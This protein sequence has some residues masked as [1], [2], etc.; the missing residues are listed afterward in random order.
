MADEGRGTFLRVLEAWREAFG[1]PSFLRAKTLARGWLL[2]TGAHRVTAAL[3]AAGVSGHLHH[4]AFHR[5]FSRAKWCPDELGRLLFLRLETLLARAGSLDVVLDDTLAEKPRGP[6]I[7][8][9]GSH[10]DAVRSSR[11]HHVLSFGHVWV[12]LAIRVQLPFASRPWALPLLFRLY[13]NERECEARGDAH[14]KKTELA[15]DM[16]DVFATWTDR[17]VRVLADQAYC[18]NTVQRDLDERFVL[19]G[20]MR[21]DAVLTALPPPNDKPK[22]G[23]PRKRG[24]LLPKPEAHA[25]NPAVPWLPVNVTL[26][27]RPQTVWVKSMLAQ[28]YQVCG[29]RLLHVVIVRI[30]GGTLPWRVFFAVD[31]DAMVADILEAYAG[32]W[33]IEATFRA[34]KQHLGFADSPARLR[35]AVERTAPFAALLLTTLAI[36]AL[37]RPGDPSLLLVPLRPWYAQKRGLSVEDLVLAA[38]RDLLAVSD[39]PGRFDD[40]RLIPRTRMSVPHQRAP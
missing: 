18:C 21:A 4:E 29:E 26:Y 38:K 13:R 7:F 14:R 8:G 31:P 16:L 40:L 36:W 24:D 1:G 35:L 2:S 5:F 3:V 22:P 15:R 9:R 12:V 19:F 32:R 28:W 11:R 23:R 39:P 30:D 25:A 17:R 27:G 37:E 10:L 6:K 33:S 34:L 20:A